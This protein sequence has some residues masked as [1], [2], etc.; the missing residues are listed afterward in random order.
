MF[1]AEFSSFERN[2]VLPR[3]PRSPLR[4]GTCGWSGRPE[5]TPAALFG[6]SHRCG[7]NESEPENGHSD[8]S[9]VTQES[10][11][12]QEHAIIVHLKYKTYHFKKDEGQHGAR[13]EKSGNHHHHCA[14]G[15]VA[16]D[17]GESRN[18]SA[19]HKGMTT[20]TL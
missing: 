9:E 18:P 4:S 10:S 17:L 15:Q 12:H 20:E 2:P 3:R 11:S 6:S 8:D 14:H 13:G 7:G 1:S 5:K 16:A 19:V